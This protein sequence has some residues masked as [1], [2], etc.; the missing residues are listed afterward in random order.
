MSNQAEIEMRENKVL[1][2]QQVNDNG[3]EKIMGIRYSTELS[4]L[5]DTYAWAYQVPIESL[6]A[7]VSASSHLP[8][9]GVGSGGSFSAAH[10]ACYLH[11]H[12]TGMISKPVTPLDLVS[13]P[14][15]LG[16]LSTMILSAGGSNADIISALDNAAQREARRL[17]VLCLRQGSALS[18]LAK[19]YRFVNLLELNPP[20][21]KDGFLATNSLLAFAVLLIR[22]YNC[23]FS[24]SETL[25]S[26]FERLFSVNSSYHA[27]IDDLLASCTP[28]WERETLVVLHGPTVS[29]A[30]VDLESKFSEAALGNVQLADFRNFAHGRHHWLAKH[31]SRTGVLAIFAM[32]ERRIA[33]RTLR[34]IPSTV[35]LAKICLPHVGPTASVA[36]LVALFHLVGAAGAQRGIDPGRPGVPEFGRRIYSLRVAYRA[37]DTAK[38]PEVTAIARKLGCDVTVA[39]TCK[40]LPMWRDA[41]RR[42][43]ENLG[44]ASFGAILFDYDGTLCDEEDRFSGPR[45]VIFRQLTRLLRAAIVVG[46]ATGRGKSVRE[47]LRKGLPKKLWQNVYLGYYNGSDVGNL[48]DD[49]HPAVSTVSNESLNAILKDISQHPVI[50]ILAKWEPRPT[51]IS[52]QPKSAAYANFVWQ[53]LQPLAQ[54]HGLRVVRS[55]HSVDVLQKGVSKRSLLA[56]LH[57]RV[58][59]GIDVLPIGDKGQWPGNDYDL[60][61]TPHSLSVDE[62]SADPNS[63]WNLAPA[64]HRGVQATLDYLDALKGLGHIFKINVH[65]LASHGVSKETLR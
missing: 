54:A 5:G 33:E 37:R 62:V 28:L 53:V 55:S 49:S 51:Q 8:L 9:L 63:C 2:G 29:T 44:R 24:A 57:D 17:I 15:H 56:H 16:S 31:E 65:R 34:L 47:A 50:S 42:F 22:A 23:A 7:A 11:Q 45:E 35:P 10:L 52:V 41:Y 64:G 43:L 58:S 13:S 14:V 27:F 40:A 12:H 32:D 30:A 18:R 20:S 61:S 48:G 39:E 38:S 1:I 21:A 6:I 59:S 60:L 46:I 26:T 19:S 25:P 3:A 4:K 36:A